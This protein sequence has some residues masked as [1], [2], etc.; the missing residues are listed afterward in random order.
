M[1]KKRKFKDGHFVDEQGNRM[2]HPIPK[3]APSRADAIDG[4]TIRRLL[5]YIGRNY[6][7]RFTAV[8]IFII[9]S[10]IVGALSSLF[11]GNVVDDFITPM[12]KQSHPNF[13]PLLHTVIVM[14][15]VFAVGAVCNL[16]YNR[17]MVTISQGIQKDIR[18]E[19]FTK[20]QDLPIKYFDTHA[21]GDIMS[22]FTNDTDTL[23][24]MLSIAIPMSF[25]ALISIVAVFI[26]ML[27][28][29]LPLTLLAV[30]CVAL[31]IFTS[32]KITGMSS[33]FFI[34]QQNSLGVVDGYIEESMSGEKVIKVFN[35][36]TPL[37]KPSTKRTNSSSAT[38]NALTPTPT[39]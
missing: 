20:M 37:S 8:V 12:L 39:S 2:D 18:D 22:R 7:F 5:A 29:S 28:T 4:A 16:L 31:M 35:T 36:K 15:V 32:G 23:R 30:V 1:A 24:Q 6:R 3:A 38:P 13:A 19:M 27:V 14:G 34:R 33:K 9:V 21:Y 10:S 26:S 11:I 17:I 25:S